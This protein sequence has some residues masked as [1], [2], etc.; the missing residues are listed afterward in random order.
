M[1]MPAAPPLDSVVL[2]PEQMPTLPPAREFLTSAGFGGAA[3][4]LAALLLAAVIL[5]AL[6]RASKRG[7]AE[8]DLQESHNR[9]VREAEQHNTAVDRCWQRL[10]W[11][12][13][14]AGIEPAASQGAT[15]GLGPELTLELLRGLL[16]DAESLGDATLTGAVTVYLSQFSQVLTQQGSVTSEPAVRSDSAEPAAAHA[17]SGQEETAQSSGS[18]ADSGDTPRPRPAKAVA[19]GQGR[20]RR[21]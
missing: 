11:V 21:Q 3:V 18:A 5:I 14:T 13:E 1:S 19:A 15:V 17:P 9:Q 2:V 16:R 4:G 10:V 20:R 12:V 6:W 8:L 7:R